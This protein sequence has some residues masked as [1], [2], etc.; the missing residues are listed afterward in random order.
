MK[1]VDPERSW[2]EL[3]RRLERERDARSIAVL[4][5]V[6][7]HMRAELRMQLPE[8]MATLVDDPIYYF[9]GFPGFDSLRGRREVEDYY[10]K[11]FD[12][13]RMHAEFETARIVVDPAAVVTEGTMVS[14]VDG[15]A[16]LAAGVTEVN[17]RKVDAVANYL[18]KTPL[19]VMWP[20]APDARIIGENIYLG[21]AR[22]DD[23]PA[24]S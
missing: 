21:A 16:V 8:T 6:R 18:S 22:Y 14:L 13:G 11:M 10:R 5:Q 23:V 15:A 7:D 3:E 4:T 2:N 12:A 1:L 19:L 24:N 17:S 9:H 20:I